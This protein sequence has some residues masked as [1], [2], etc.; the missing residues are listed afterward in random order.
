LDATTLPVVFLAGDPV[1]SGLA[2]NL[3]RPGGNATGVSLLTSDLTAKRLELLRMS[4]PRVRRFILL[5]N[6]AAKKLGITI[7]ES[8]LL[9][10]NEVI[11]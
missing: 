10:A 9:R 7:S 8:I 1:A 11:R 6:S 3:A 5:T 4:A 2:A